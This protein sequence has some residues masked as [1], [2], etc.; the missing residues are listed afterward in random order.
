[1]GIEKIDE[2]FAVKSEIKRDGIRFYDIEDEPFRIYGV[3]KENGR[4]VRLPEQTAKRVSEGVEVL[5]KN[6]AGGR[7]R[8][9]TD[10]SYI[11]IHAVM[12]NIEVMPHFPLAGSAG[13]DMFIKTDGG[14][15]YGGTFMPPSDMQNGYD[16]IIDIP[17]P[18]MKTVTVELPLYCNVVGLY[19]GLDEN[20]RLERAEDYTFENPIVYYG[21]SI[22]QGGCA[23]KPGSSYQS[24][25]SRMFDVNY[26]NLGFSGSCKGEDAMAEYIASLDMSAFVYDYDHNAP[27][28][29]FLEETHERFF[30]MFRQAKPDT[31]VI[32]MS[33]PKYYLTEDDILRRDIIRKTYENA[34]NSGDKNVYFI[35]GSSLMDD[36]IKDNGTVDGC[37]PTDS[38]FACM[39]KRLS[40]E[41]ERFFRS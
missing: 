28:A 11:A 6:T 17:Q 22:T 4:F 32:M 27:T 2:N 18:G 10:S 9:A 23:S 12:D 40:A 33:R 1:M 41:L 29:S 35:D 34:V 36:F 39:A 37:H 14:D 20:A 15:I 16:E 19:I 38:G 21:S 25:I 5:R 30:Q 3:F 31:P 26:I 7:V 24:I 13:F 8:F